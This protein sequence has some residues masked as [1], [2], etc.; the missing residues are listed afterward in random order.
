MIKKKQKLQG[1]KYRI[2]FLICLVFLVIVGG[3]VT[4]L[5]VV[6]KKIAPTTQ[7]SSQVFGIFSG[8]LPCADCSGLKTTLTLYVDAQTHQPTTYTLSS[9]YKGKSQKPFISYGTWI[10]EKGDEVDPSAIL[11]VL[12]PNRPDQEQFWVKASNTQLK[13]L[14]NNKS[15]IRSPFPLILTKE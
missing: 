5:V 15:E 1:E 11:Y 12:D 2:V 8:T 7:V 6:Q 9:L 3:V 10:I 13:M 14:D 4:M